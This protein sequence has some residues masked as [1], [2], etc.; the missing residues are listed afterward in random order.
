MLWNK[1][2]LR[3]KNVNKLWSL[4]GLFAIQILI[5]WA[6][7][8]LPILQSTSVSISSHFTE[9]TVLLYGSLMC[10]LSF[11]LFQ[12]VFIMKFCLLEKME[13]K[14]LNPARFAYTSVILGDL[15]GGGG[16][17]CSVYRGQN[18]PESLRPRWKCFKRLHFSCWSDHFSSFI[19][20]KYFELKR[21]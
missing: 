19:F 1:Q 18:S 15:T 11:L 13:I 10:V 9:P 20:K 6:N 14:E 8:T 3:H 17:W 12:T 16:N 7:I 2:L 21:E 5:D 4:K